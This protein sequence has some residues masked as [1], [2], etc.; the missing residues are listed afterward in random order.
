MFLEALAGARRS[1]L[2]LELRDSY[3]LDDPEFIRWQQGYRINREDRASWWR[4]WCDT[5]ATAAARG[6]EFRRA[7]VVSEPVHDY[8]R[9]EYDVTFPN[10]LA[11]EQVRWLPRRN[12]TD[13]ALPGVDFWLFDD[14]VA[15]FNHFTGNGQWADPDM[16]TTTDP[17]VVKLCSSAFDSV[18]SRAID[19]EQYEI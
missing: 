15:L 17:A 13:L 10:I 3:M 16:E 6:V 4:P 14:Q 5:V 9:Y 2:H 19:H 8:I 1:A 12:T 7:R 18:W 11:G